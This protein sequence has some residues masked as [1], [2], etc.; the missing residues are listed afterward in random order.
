MNNPNLLMEEPSNSA[1]AGNKRH[2]VEDTARLT[3]DDNLAAVLQTIV[4]TQRVI[5][6]KLTALT[7]GNIP[8]DAP[9]LDETKEH[10]S[11]EQSNVDETMDDTSAPIHEKVSVS[12]NITDSFLQ[13]A[14]IKCLICRS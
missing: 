2:R 12:T 10:Q 13:D 6:E 14:K 7:S 9:P 5:T 3:N 1:S 4:N 8:A 11:P